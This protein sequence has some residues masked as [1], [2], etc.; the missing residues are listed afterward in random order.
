MSS[1]SGMCVGGPRDAHVITGSCPTMVV[2]VLEP[3]S[4]TWRDEG[5]QN[6]YSRPERKEVTYTHRIA[7]RSIDTP[8]I[9]LWVP[10]DVL[11]A[12][13]VRQVFETYAKGATL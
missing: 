9:N 13:A 11:T 4:H 7:Y 2:P 8:Q 10:K 6:G 3:V 5:D 1:F 12:Q